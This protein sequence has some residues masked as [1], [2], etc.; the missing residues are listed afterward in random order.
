MHWHEG[1]FLRPQHFQAA[2]RHHEERLRRVRAWSIP[3]AWG[4]Y[5]I[6]RDIDEKTSNFFSLEGLKAILPDGLP[7]FIERDNLRSDIEISANSRFVLNLQKELAREREPRITVIRADVENGK[8]FRILIGIPRPSA[9]PADVSPLDLSYEVRDMLAAD[10]ART[11][12]SL[13]SGVQKIKLRQPNVRLF[14]ARGMG[15]DEPEGF[16]TLP[17]A[18]V[19]SNAGGFFFDPEF[20]AP[21]LIWGAHRRWFLDKIFAVVRQW[22]ASLFHTVGSPDRASTLRPFAAVLAE[23]HAVVGLLMQDQS[24]HPFPI[25]QELSRIQIRLKALRAEPKLVDPDPYRHDDLHQCFMTLRNQIQETLVSLKEE[26]PKV[27]QN[28]TVW[29]DRGSPGNALDEG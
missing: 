18:Q 24:T 1:M 29:E 27:S 14:L 22:L 20:L 2:E 11:P 8:P 3:H 13:T 17:I 12:E 4:V 15:L 26:L 7:L 9:L 25:Y 16:V 10:D 6:D 5:S 23:L 28:D 21:A 19:F